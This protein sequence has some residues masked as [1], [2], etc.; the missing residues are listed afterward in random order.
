MR[1]SNDGD[2]F[3]G[4]KIPKIN[5]V[6]RSPLS[7]VPAWLCHYH[8]SG[9]GRRKYAETKR[10]AQEFTRFS[11]PVDW[12]AFSANDSANSPQSFT[13]RCFEKFDRR[14]NYPIL[15]IT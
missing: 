4:C 8:I 1:A 10:F 2:F 12:E 3:V 14:C 9:G 5:N 11:R 15:K 13:S 6:V 7:K